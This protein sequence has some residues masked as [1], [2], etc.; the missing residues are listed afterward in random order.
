[1]VNRLAGLSF[2]PQSCFDA[3]VR[4]P[5]LRQIDPFNKIPNF[6][7]TLHVGLVIEARLEEVIDK[8]FSGPGIVLQFLIEIGLFETNAAVWIDAAANIA[9]FCSRSLSDSIMIRLGPPVQSGEQ[10]RADLS[11]V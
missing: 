7:L 8:A 5:K 9:D 3:F 2:A 6:A 1:L 11:N 10:I 4:A